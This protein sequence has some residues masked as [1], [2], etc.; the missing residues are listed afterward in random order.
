M[1]TSSP[2]TITLHFHRQKLVLAF[3]ALPVLIVIMFALVD[4]VA[5]NL[6][7]RLA[8][9]PAE[10]APAAQ[11]V[12][13]TAPQETY[14]ATGS[15]LNIN[16]FSLRIP[17]PPLDSIPYDVRDSLLN[18]T[19]VPVKKRWLWVPPGQ[20]ITVTGGENGD[21]KVNVPSGSIWWKEFYIETDR[22]TFMIERRIVA[23]VDVSAR[24]PE[25][26]AYYTAH[27]LPEGARDDAPIMVSSTSEE[28]EKYMFQ[29][30]EWMPT[31]QEGTHMEVRFADS[32]GVEYGYV[33]P[34]QTQCMAC[35]GGAAGAYPNGD[36]DPIFAFG[37]HPNNLTP[38][39]FTALVE[40]GWIANAEQLLTPDYRGEM[41]DTVSQPVLQELQTS[42]VVGLLRNNCASCHNGSTYSA[43]NFT[44]FVID[45][46]KN[47]T[48]D[49]LR[50]L[51][52]V[53]GKMVEGAFSLVTPGDLSRSELW[54]RING[55]DGRRRM[56]PVEGGLPDIDPRV[57][58]LLENWIVQLDE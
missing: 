42:Q 27:Y 41:P 17:P 34:G 40:R 22:G 52:G 20:Q 38:E 14:P 56:P 45:P 3:T 5:S 25:G 11:P 33:F 10:S 9:V 1:I 21:V 8:G 6:D 2:R 16:Q 57:I 29:P 43:A 36:S 50:A 24:N 46:N 7:R 28:A 58:T 30:H 39:S 48:T 19:N 49:E 35:H 54:L 53:D 32:R 23:K 51:L 44:A 37:L 47:Y 31:R 13:R 18:G 26:W 12:A 55:H 15:E 4:M